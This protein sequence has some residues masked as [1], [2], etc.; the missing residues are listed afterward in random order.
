MPPAAAAFTRQTLDLFPGVKLNVSLD[1]LRAMLAAYAEM[2]A[3]KLREHLRH[4]LAGRR[5]RRGKPPECVWPS[6]PTTRRFR[7]RACRAS[8][9]PRT[10]PII[11]A[12]LDQS[13]ANGLC[14]CTGSL[15]ARGDNDLPGIVH[16]LGSA[17]PCRPSAQCAARARRRVLR[18]AHLGGSTDMYAVVRALLDEQAARR[19]AGRVDWQLTFRPDH[20]HML[21]DDFRRPAPTCPGYPLLGRM[22]GLAELR[23]LQVGVS[24]SLAER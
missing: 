17:Y 23:G 3:A 5:A 14:Y 2:S 6:I 7:A 18:G 24:R 19:R 22:R 20:G 13:P 15:G 16:R 21:L 11:R 9:P 4:F 1:G 12:M 10:S 8:S